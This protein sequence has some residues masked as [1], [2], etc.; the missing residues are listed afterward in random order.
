ME[1]K[2]INELIEQI[3]DVDLSTFFEALKR[4]PNAQGYNIGAISEY[5]LMKDLEGKRYELKRIT[6]K[7]QG[8]KLLRHHGDYY[9]KRKESDKWYVLESKGLK[10]NTEKW[11]K[12]DTKEGLKRFLK[13]W[14]KTSGI[15][16]SNK[17]IEDW[18]EGNFR[19]KLEEL[20]VK[21]L[22]T[23]F[24]S[25]KSKH[26]EINTSRKDEFDY[27]A[28]DIFLRTGEHRFIFADPRHLPTS[29]N[30]PN[31]LQQNYVIDVLVEGK[32]E[33]VSIKPPWYKELKDIWDDSRTPIKEGEMQVD[34]RE[35]KSW[36][37]ILR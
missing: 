35:L 1:L 15:W 26:R 18:C 7:W 11:V 22:M 14:N 2:E 37:E 24:V 3:F 32:K 28:V 34:E 9:I 31:H 17:E 8:P 20:K 10:S 25:G 27:I 5:L 21:I 23:H 12:L 13:K 30:H 19:E 4:S 6:E 16:S 33:N 29:K 36:R